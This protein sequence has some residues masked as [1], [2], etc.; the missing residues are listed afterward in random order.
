M[1]LYHYPSFHLPAKDWIEHLSLRGVVAD[2]VLF[3]PPYS[4]R[5]VMEVYA[6]I[7]RQF[8]KRDAQQMGCWTAERDGL[9][10]MLK[11][12]AGVSRFRSGGIRLDSEKSAG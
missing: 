6:G 7:G 11:S 9:A 5:Q 8:T 3:D 12:G 2:A 1:K 10:S 4:H